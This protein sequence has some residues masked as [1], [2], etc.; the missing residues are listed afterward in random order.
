MGPGKAAVPLTPRPPRPCPSA[1][2]PSQTQLQFSWN[3]PA[4]PENL[5]ARFTNPSPIVIEKLKQPVGNNQQDLGAGDSLGLRD[6]IGFSV[7]SEEKLNWAVQLAKRD[8]KRRHLEE[9]V[10]ECL[11]PPRY[12]GQ[13]RHRGRKGFGSLAGSKASEPHLKHEHPLGNASKAETTGSGAKV[14]LY[15]PNRARLDPSLPDSPPTRDPG[16]GPQP[17]TLEVR[18]LQ[19]ELQNYVQKIEELAKN[20]RSEEILDP[21]QER[22]VRVRR[23][24]QAVRSARMLYVLQHQVREIQ[25]DLDRLSPNKI[26]HTKKSRAVARLA[27]AHRGAIRAL[28]TFAAR[29]ANQSEQQLATAQCKELGNLI[30]QLSLCSA[31]L[32]MDSS[33]P[34][35]VIDLLLQI[36]D[37]DSLLAQREPPKKEKKTP[38]LPQAESLMGGDRGPRREKKVH[39]PEP[40]HPSVAR[41]LLPDEPR[42]SKAPAL[43]S[44]SSHPDATV[45]ADVP[46]PEREASLQAQQDV[47]AR[48]GPVKTQPGLK[49]GPPRKKGVLSTR[50]QGCCWLPRTKTAQPQAKQARFQEPTMAFRLKETKPHVRESRTPWVPP[51]HTSP[52]ASPPRI[53]CREVDRSPRSREASPESEQAGEGRSRDPGKAALRPDG[54]SP[55]QI[56]EKIERAVREHLEPLLVKA[57]KVNLA[58][59]SNVGLSDNQL[60]TQ[61]VRKAAAGVSGRGLET[62]VLEQRKK[63]QHEISSAFST[64]DLETMLQR[65]EEIERS[66]EAVRRRYNQIVYSDP[67]FWAQ[68]ERGERERTARGQEPLAPHPIQITKPNR[69]KEPQVDIVLEKPL[70]AN[71]VDKD[72]ETEEQQEPRNRLPAASAWPLPRHKEPSA[73]L[74]LPK[75]TLQNIHDYSARYE[76]HLRRIS[77]EEVGSFNP[78]QIAQS[79]AEELIEEALGDVAAEL[80]DLCEDYAEAIFTSEF[81][82]AAE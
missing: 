8:M 29:F 27:A 34:D 33:V 67:E 82:Q 68:E 62:F 75:N 50:P 37:L 19:K 48:P 40:R 55:S 78:W 56:A 72:L 36:E 31:R 69:W 23:Q 17:A 35:V 44:R 26:K 38:T 59:E 41:R 81:L 79:L 58:L 12:P 15:A 51:S 73:F 46:V 71:A 45:Q 76:Q 25:E 80:Q 65:M 61:E 24:E 3:T 42:E 53:P 30:R 52:L 28:Q 64:S 49:G 9:Q 20:E 7:V 47:W 54:T 2:R 11:E 63:A 43:H 4:L 18:R 6:S 21:D 39:V 60:P 5:A 77:H 13:G 1:A 70:D 16:L 66:Q 14:Y 32:E 57:Q 22:R 74:S 10:R